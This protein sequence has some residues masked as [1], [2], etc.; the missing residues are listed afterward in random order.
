M[1]KL[2]AKGDKMPASPI[3]KLVP[4]STA[5]KAAGKHVYHFNIGQPDIASPQ[6]ALDAV[7]NIDRK[8]IEY[9]DSDGFASYRKAWRLLHPCGNSLLMQRTS[10]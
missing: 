4:Y 2:S 3:R 9:S 5:A 8:L 10:W 1:P 7:R 6:V